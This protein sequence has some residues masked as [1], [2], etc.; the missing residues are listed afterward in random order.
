MIGAESL[1]LFSNP[2]RNSGIGSTKTGLQLFKSYMNWEGKD[3]SWPGTHRAASQRI[4]IQDAQLEIMIS[5]AP[6]FQGSF[7]EA[8]RSLQIKS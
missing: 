7:L 5:P 8:F 2:G 3:E 6:G 1:R 4:S